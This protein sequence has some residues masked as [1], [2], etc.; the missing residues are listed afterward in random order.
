MAFSS[1]SRVIKGSLRR[2]RTRRGITSDIGSIASS[3]S[4][5][6]RSSARTKSMPNR[7]AKAAEDCPANAPIVLRPSARKD[8]AVASPIRN[9]SI[10]IDPTS[11]R[12]AAPSGAL[13]PSR[14]SGAKRASAKAVPGVAAHA[15]RA[16]RPRPRIRRNISASTARSPPNK[17]AQPVMSRKS[18]C[19]SVNP[20]TGAT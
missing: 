9:P 2:R 18:A 16:V 4:P 17:C 3:S 20:F 12:N 7:R 10:G 15:A 14:A 13:S 1:P 5:R 19:V 11:A 6:A 8:V